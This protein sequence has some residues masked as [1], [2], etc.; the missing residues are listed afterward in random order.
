MLV[1]ILPFQ[2]V[3][4]GNGIVLVYM[5]RGFGVPAPF[6]KAGNAFSMYFILK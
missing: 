6:W 4:Q 3:E 1:K 2:P 5:L